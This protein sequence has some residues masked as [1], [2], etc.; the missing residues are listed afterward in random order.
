MQNIV[1]PGH[2]TEIQ[3]GVCAFRPNFNVIVGKIFKIFHKN[4]YIINV[5]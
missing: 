3:K 4:K 2:F 1:K 5:E